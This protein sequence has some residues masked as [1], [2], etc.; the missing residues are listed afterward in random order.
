[1][2]HHSLNGDNRNVFVFPAG[3]S[4][5]AADGRQIGSDLASVCVSAVF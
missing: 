3:A 1:M 2:L 4:T 5:V